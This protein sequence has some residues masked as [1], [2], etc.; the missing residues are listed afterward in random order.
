MKK[1]VVDVML[2]MTI[3]CFATTF[4]YSQENSVTGL[5]TTFDSIPVTNA[6]V[7]VKSSNEVVHTDSLGNFTIRCKPSDVVKI[8]AR[9]FSTKRVKLHKKVSILLVNLILKS[10][11]KGENVNI[12]YGHV[13]DQDKL[14]A[15]S[16]LSDKHSEF[17]SY[18]NMFDLIRGR[19][20]GVQVT[21]DGEIIVRGIKSLNASSAALIVVDGTV[22]DPGYLYNLSPQIVKRIDILKDAAAAV[23]G[24]RGANG[25]VL[26]ET[27]KGGDD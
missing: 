26:I 13:R 8:S 5:V 17:S 10:Q 21:S 23:Y 16:S 6:V 25:V 9:G 7:K 2:I 14:S 22:V 18:S 27:K 19:F 3:I 20:A 12:G 24:S 11:P 15:I 1:I 4:S